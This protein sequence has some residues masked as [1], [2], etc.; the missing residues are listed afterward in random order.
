MLRNPRS[1]RLA[2]TRDPRKPVAPVTK[3]SSSG[4]TMAF[5]NNSGFIRK[6]LLFSDVSFSHGA[7]ADQRQQFSKMI[8]QTNQVLHEDTLPEQQ[9][10]RQQHRVGRHRNQRL[11]D[12]NDSEA[13]MQ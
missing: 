2:T 12:F 3:I 6:A 4:L 8:E 11:Y 1:I 13:R 7:D 5:L 10:H 9:H